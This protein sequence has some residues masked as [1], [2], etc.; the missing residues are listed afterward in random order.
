MHEFVSIIISASRAAA[1]SAADNKG[2]VGCITAHACG[3]IFGGGR[4][5]ADGFWCG[6]DRHRIM[7]KWQI[8]LVHGCAFYL[9]NHRI[10]RKS[11][12]FMPNILVTLT[13]SHVTFA[14]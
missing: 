11:P 8:L 10:W 12:V 5:F 4:T 13:Q 7:T 3:N 6:Q 2:N 9:N 14:K 1:Y